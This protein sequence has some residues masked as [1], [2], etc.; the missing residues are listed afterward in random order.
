MINQRS[1]LL[2]GQYS[3]IY[4]PERPSGFAVMI[5]G[6]RNHFVEEKTSFWLQHPGRNEIVTQLKSLG[7]M[8]FSSNFY[9]ASWGSDRA[10]DLAKRLY[11][12]VMKS[13]ILNERFHILAEG[14]GAL[15][16]MKVADLLKDQIRSV[17]FLNPCLS[18]QKKIQ[19]EKEQKFFYKK[20]INEISH[21]YGWN[22]QESAEF[23]RSPEAENLEISVPLKIIHILGNGA[24]DQSELYKSIQNK[25]HLEIQFLLAEKRYK[26]A[27]QARSFFRKYETIL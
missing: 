7:Y 19:K 20:I 18:L 13:E 10:A 16:A 22:K 27:A 23:L 11:H 14:T 26:I 9:G 2:D 12:M 24:E 21:A 15:T 4:Y 5:I 1:F 17:V 8:L 25:S 3:M 6:D